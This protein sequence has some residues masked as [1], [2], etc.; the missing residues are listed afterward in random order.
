MVTW[1]YLV[2]ISYIIGACCIKR[3]APSNNCQHVKGLAVYIRS[4]CS[5]TRFRCFGLSFGSIYDRVYFTE[6]NG[7]TVERVQL[8]ARVFE[9]VIV[10]PAS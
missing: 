10:W 7:S 1:L 2:T 3:Q 5:Q 4:H 8:I 6:R 9:H